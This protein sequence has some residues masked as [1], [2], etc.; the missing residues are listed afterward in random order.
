[1]RVRRKS[2]HH[3][4]PRSRG[5]SNHPANLVLWDSLFHDAYHRMFENLTLEEAIEMLK[6]VSYSGTHWNQSALSQLRKHLKEK[7]DGENG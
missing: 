4:V 6:I 5:G 3:I 1:M 2:V 7:T